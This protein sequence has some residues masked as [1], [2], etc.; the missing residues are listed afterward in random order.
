M[1]EFQEILFTETGGKLETGLCARVCNPI[2]YHTAAFSHDTG[3]LFNVPN[4]KPKVGYVQNPE[5][6]PCGHIIS[7]SFLFCG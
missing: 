7:C 6:S 5:K 1:A 2:V 3:S 4:L